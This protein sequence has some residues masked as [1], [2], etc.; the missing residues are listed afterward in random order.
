MD[1][2]SPVL[3]CDPPQ[4]GHSFTGGQSCVGQGAVLQGMQTGCSG[5]LVV[6]HGLHFV[7]LVG[8]SSRGMQVL[9]RDEPGGVALGRAVYVRLGGFGVGVGVGVGFEITI[10]GP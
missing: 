7:H 9:L 2:R 4:L 8:Q 3:N 10:G 6:T 5:Q 1:A